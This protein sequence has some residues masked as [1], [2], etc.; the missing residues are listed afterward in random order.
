MPWLGAQW[1]KIVIAMI[2]L[3]R[4]WE[5][6][7]PVEEFVERRLGER[8]RT[9]NI[10]V[11]T[12]LV[13]L[14]EEILKTETP[15]VEKAAA[16]AAIETAEQDPKVQA[17]TAASAALLEAAQNLKAAVNAPPAPPAA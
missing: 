16:T 9:M 2:A 14:I 10:P 12:Q 13:H 17:V 7:K 1:H 15:F 8:R 11:L 5:H 4:L 6:I 3:E